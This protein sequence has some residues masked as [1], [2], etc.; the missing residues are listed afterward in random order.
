MQ[1]I[2]E[3]FENF[4]HENDYYDDNDE[5]DSDD[6]ALP[7]EIQAI[8]LLNDLNIESAEDFRNDAAELA[9]HYIKIFFNN[10]KPDNPL[11]SEYDLLST[12]K[13]YTV[14]NTSI[15]SGVKKS[16]KALERYIVITQEDMNKAKKN[17]DVT[18]EIKLVNES[19]KSIYKAGIPQQFAG[20]MMILYLEYCRGIKFE[21]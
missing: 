6:D 12:D 11:P 19:L 8:N 9:R 21:S 20:G 18:E 10:K 7:E 1:K 17:G 5:I 2:L 15:I 14:L 4:E 13:I 3:N 16:Y